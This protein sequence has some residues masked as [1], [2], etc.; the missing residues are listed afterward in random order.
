MSSRP[1]ASI[2]QGRHAG[3]ARRVDDLAGLS[4][5]SRWRGTALLLEGVAELLQDPAGPADRADA[6]LLSFPELGT[7][8]RSEAVQR[9]RELG[10]LGG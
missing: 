5:T 4:P 1:G 10:L 8:S 3:Y 2:E 9:L 7:S 6:I